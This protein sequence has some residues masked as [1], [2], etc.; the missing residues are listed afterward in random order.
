MVSIV[1]VGKKREVFRAIIDVWHGKPVEK[2]LREYHD[3][4]RGLPGYD[5]EYIL[6]AL[7]WILEQ[8]D[9]NFTGRPERKQKELDEICKKCQITVPEGREGS[10]LA[11]S[12]LCD[13]ISGVHPVE[14]FLK[15][16][17]DVRPVK[18]R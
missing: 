8:E 14:A 13:I 17:L 4:V 2:V 16:N 15:A 1:P 3:K 12:L 11:I 10:Q 7:K 18:R 9:V 5:L 6:Y